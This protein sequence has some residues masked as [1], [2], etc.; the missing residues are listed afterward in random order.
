MKSTAGQYFD[1]HKLS[2]SIAGSDCFRDFQSITQA[3][4]QKLYEQAVQMHINESF[5]QATKAHCFIADE[6]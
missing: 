2:S 1:S 4:S 5:A 3:S 6:K